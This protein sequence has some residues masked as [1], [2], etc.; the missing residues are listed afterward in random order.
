M[1]FY[2]FLFEIFWDYQQVPTWFTIIMLFKWSLYNKI[3]KNSFDPY[4]SINLDK[5]DVF[6]LGRPSILYTEYMKL[7][8]HVYPAIRFW[9]LQGS[10]L[11]PPEIAWIKIDGHES[12]VFDADTDESMIHN[13]C[14]DLSEQSNK[15]TFLIF[16]IYRFPHTTIFY[17][18]IS[19]NSM[20]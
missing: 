5:L 6:R 17:H 3:Y 16:V 8:N 11:K 12:K 10:S 7:F 1:I 19:N 4:S 13:C 2:F 9:L 18:Q 15:S 14:R 20:H